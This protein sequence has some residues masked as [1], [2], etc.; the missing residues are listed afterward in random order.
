RPFDGSERNQRMHLMNSVLSLPLALPSWMGNSLSVVAM[1]FGF[2]F[3]V[4]FHELGHFLAAKW[5][6]IKVEQFAVG[7]GQALFSWRK[8]MGGKAG[9]TQKEYLRRVEEHLSAKDKS[10]LQRKAKI[11][12][13]EEQISKTADERRQ[14][15]T[16]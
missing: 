3:V 1:V 12:Y 11:E 15:E 5:V 7:F 8:G 2:G 14:G 13:S 16:E 4:F 6:G 10:E 9:T